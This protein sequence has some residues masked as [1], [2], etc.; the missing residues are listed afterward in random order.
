MPSRVVVVTGAT[1]G[2]GRATA[3]ALGR[4][5]DAV[6]LLGR[7]RAGLEAAAA[8][9][10]RA[11]GRALTVPTDVADADAVDAAA[12]RVGD[13]LGP[14][15]VWVNNAMA[16]VFGKVTSTSPEE[17]RRATEVTYLGFVWGTM[18]ALRRMVPRDRGS[19]VQV[20]SALSYRAIPLQAAY[21]G[22]KFAVRGFTDSLRS[23]LLH[24]GSH[25]R[26]TMVQLPA[27]N[28]PQFDWGASKMPKQPRPVAPIFDPDVAAEAVVWATD[29]DRRELWV[30]ARN[31]LT[32]LG[33]KVAPGALDVM[34]ART[35]FDGQQT[36]QPTGAD[37]PANLFEPADADDD[38]GVRGAFGSEA[39]HRSVQLE[40]ARRRPFSGVLSRPLGAVIARLLGG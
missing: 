15:D 19:I 16:T 38:F 10:E 27:V 20:G 39:H 36:D 32:M 23:E 1:A 35:G 26:L 7:G 28:T 25:V 17:F 14:I 34:L 12:S 9:V 2:V 29:H 8:D 3:I 5:G 33:A 11:G 24:D 18:A 22:S 13:E 40:L 21:C 4:R 6:A 31:V 30:G 37:R